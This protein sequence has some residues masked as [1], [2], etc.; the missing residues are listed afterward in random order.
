M[1]TYGNDLVPTTKSRLHVASMELPMYLD[2]RSFG[3]G[4]DVTGSRL[5]EGGP[6][7]GEVGLAGRDVSVKLARG[8]VA[9]GRVSR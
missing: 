3:S 1:A 5:V 8:Y 6:D 2:F 9:A 7:L 4:G